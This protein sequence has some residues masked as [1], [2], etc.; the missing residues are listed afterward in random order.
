MKFIV[1]DKRNGKDI[2]KD[3]FWV[4]TSDGRLGYIDY[5]DFIGLTYAEAHFIPYGV[6]GVTLLRD[7][8]WITYPM[9]ANNGR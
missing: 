9:E 8:R 5:G 4:I 6:E 2:T 1:I 3:Y 7:G